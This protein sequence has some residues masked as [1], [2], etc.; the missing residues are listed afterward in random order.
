MQSPVIQGELQLQLMSAMWRLQEGTV[1]Q[2]RQ[3]VPARYQS[4]YT[5]VQTVLNRLAERGMLTRQRR[6]N[7]IVYAPAISEDEY[8][9]Q[10]VESALSSATPG[11]RDAV[12]AR[13]IGGLEKDEL[14]ELRKLAK[15]ID[16]KRKPRK[17]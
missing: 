11:A 15:D 9:A 5:T 17:R 16:A 1:E 8:V 2:I 7:T 13:L 6:G 3:A 4:A 10:T 14:S 12:L